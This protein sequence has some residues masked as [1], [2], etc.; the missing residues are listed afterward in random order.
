MAYATRE[1]ALVGEVKDAQARSVKLEGEVSRREEAL[2]RASEDVQA[3]NEAVAKA[4]AKVAALEEEL[5]SA[6]RDA[7][8]ARALTKAHDAKIT[9]ME[10]ERSEV[11]S[12]FGMVQASR[13][14]L[15]V[16]KVRLEDE[17]RLSR[18]EA[19]AAQARLREEVATVERLSAVCHQQRVDYL[20]SR[21]PSLLRQAVGRMARRRL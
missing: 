5:R 18:Q 12:R 16:D 21:R 20:S 9:T 10:R 4:L 13:D 8:A 14:S 1:Q 6:K 17:V 15:L 7:A 3:S 2:R 19:A 11:T